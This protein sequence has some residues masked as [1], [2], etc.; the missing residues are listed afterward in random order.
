MSS[1]SRTLEAEVTPN[2][3]GRFAVLGIWCREVPWLGNRA[4]TE[5]GDF[6]S[7][8]DLEGYG[9]LGSEPLNRM[10]WVTRSSGLF[11]AIVFSKAK[12][13]RVQDPKYLMLLTVEFVE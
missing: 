1:E 7:R 4:H 6:H 13:T 8:G 3:C 5:N 10:S 9:K 2:E 11:L 12:R